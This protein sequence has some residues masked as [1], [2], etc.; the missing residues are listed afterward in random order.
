MNISRIISF[1]CI[2]FF[3]G[4]IS[5]QIKGNGIMETRIRSLSLFTELEVDFP[6][7]V[8]VNCQELAKL[9]ITADENV[10]EGIAIKHEGGK[11]RILQEKWIQPTK[12]VQITIG[13]PFLHKLSTS[14]YGE[15]FINNL[16]GPFFSVNNPVG[17]VHL[18]GKIE[19]LEVNMRNG[20]L[21]ALQLHSK[22]ATVNI[23]GYGEAKI[24]A[25]EHLKARVGEHKADKWL[26]KGVNIRLIKDDAENWITYGSWEEKKP[27]APQ[28]IDLKLKNN[29][30]TK[31]DFIVEGP[32]GNRFGYGFPIKAG[33]IRKENFP[34]GSRIY[35]DKLL[36]RKLIHTVSAADANQT[37]SLFK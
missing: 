24:H 18:A 29:S 28:R 25:I 14:G 27:D 10:F 8:T 6:A 11:L 2:L 37:V 26:D 23:E 19:Q 9:E 21:E 5:A 32:R 15:F 17:T 7:H 35:L 13:A 4:E 30:G 20:K 34:I 31:A 36:G 3:L 16:D 33:A 1:L 12:N 22:K